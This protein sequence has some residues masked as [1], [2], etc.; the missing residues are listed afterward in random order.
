VPVVESNLGPVGSGHSDR[1]IDCLRPALRLIECGALL[2]LPLYAITKCLYIGVTLRF[3]YA[4]EVRPKALSADEVSVKLCL[5][6][7]WT[8]IDT[9]QGAADYRVRLD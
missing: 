2:V 6:L 1:N 5:S 3:C 4:I 9:L 8:G 7:E